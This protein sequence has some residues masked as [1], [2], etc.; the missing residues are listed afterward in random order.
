[1]C[2]ML[3][4]HTTTIEHKY[5]S[6]LPPTHPH[7]CMY[8]NICMYKTKRTVR[9][10]VVEDLGERHA[11]PLGL[12][13]CEEVGDGEEGLADLLHVL[14]LWVFVC[15]VLIIREGGMGTASANTCAHKC[16]TIK[17]IEIKTKTRQN[18]PPQPSPMH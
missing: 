17:A 4:P 6:P 12:Q 5:P 7:T 10:K 9:V 2:V 16:Q 8:I 14:F 3:F 1:M 15:F 11:L 18:A 13:L